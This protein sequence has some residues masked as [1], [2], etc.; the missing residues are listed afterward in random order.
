MRTSSPAA[1]PKPTAS[2][3]HGNESVALC[4]TTLA[5][6]CYLKAGAITCGCE[7]CRM[8][9]AVSS[10][11]KVSVGPISIGVCITYSQP[12]RCDV[13]LENYLPTAK[14]LYL[15]RKQPSTLITVNTCFMWCAY[16]RTRLCRNVMGQGEM[17]EQIWK[18]VRYGYTVLHAGLCNK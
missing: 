16:W 12:C 6:L 11:C 1:P 13:L 3:M 2:R 10:A 5:D 17:L 15:L 4:G 9:F 18:A 14:P 7:S 8:T